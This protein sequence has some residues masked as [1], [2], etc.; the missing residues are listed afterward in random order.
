MPKRLTKEEFVARAKKIHADKYDYSKTDYINTSTKVCITCPIHGDFWQIAGDHLNGHGCPKCAGL[1]SPTT[2]EFVERA[3][4]IGDNAERYNYSKVVYVNNSTKVLIKCNKCG[5]EF[6][7]TPDKHLHGEGCPVC[8]N[9]LIHEK[10]KGAGNINA[11]RIRYGVGIIDTPYNVTPLKSFYIWNNMLQ[12]CYSEKQRERYPSYKDCSVCKEWF[13]FSNFK[14]WFDENYVEGFHLDKDLFSKN[15]KEYSPETCCFIPPEINRALAF[16][17]NKNNGMPLGVCFLKESNVY[18]GV[19][20]NKRLKRFKTKEEAHRHY[21]E[22]KTKRIKELAEKYKDV[23]TERVY[24][25]LL[26]YELPE[27][28]NK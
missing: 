23:I 13:L 11:R 12:R 6:L 22:Y 27:M 2:E 8:A 16:H 20:A 19:G 21:V 24:N 25:A 14:K 7:Q 5:I 9:I 17:R 1:Y 15:N 28:Y 4:K 26:N 18:L 3:K 10:Q